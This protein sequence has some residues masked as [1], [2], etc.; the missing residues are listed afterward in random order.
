MGTGAQALALP[1]DELTAVVR[2]AAILARNYG[3]LLPGE[4]H[5]VIEADETTARVVVRED[6][7]RVIRARD[8]LAAI[9]TDREYTAAELDEVRR[10]L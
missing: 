5:A 7:A 2:I 6:D 10:A 4:Y 8:L 9:A 1:Q 3:T